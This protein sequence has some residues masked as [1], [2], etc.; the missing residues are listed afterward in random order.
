MWS[1][2]HQGAFYKRKLYPMQTGIAWIRKDYPNEN[3]HE[4][5]KVYLHSISDVD[6]DCDAQYS[7]ILALGKI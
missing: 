7:G 5:L 3:R 6:T 2:E 4:L 1:K